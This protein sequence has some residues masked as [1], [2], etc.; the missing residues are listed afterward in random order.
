MI[1]CGTSDPQFEACSHLEL[2]LILVVCFDAF[3]VSTAEEKKWGIS[4][5]ILRTEFHI[6]DIF[7]SWSHLQ[8]FGPIF[9]IPQCIDCS[10]CS[11]IDWLWPLSLWP[12]MWFSLLQRSVTAQFFGF[13]VYCSCT[14]SGC[15]C[16][17]VLLLFL[18]Y[19]FDFML[20]T[21]SPASLRLLDSYIQPQIRSLVCSN[22]AMSWFPL[23]V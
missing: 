11:L 12:T 15:F 7:A 10:C 9:Y 6:W 23:L 13:P 2:R 20:G 17:T 21:V 18:Q 14:P 8:S 22:P 4:I 16:F 3:P 5:S 1:C 19:M